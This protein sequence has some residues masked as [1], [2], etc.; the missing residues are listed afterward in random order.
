[1][2]AQAQTS[3]RRSRKTLAEAVITNAEASAADHQV[4]VALAAYFIAERR[5][6]E[7]GHELDDWLAAEAQLAQAEQP[8][9][10]SSIQLIKPENV[11]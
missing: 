4:K 3:G 2:N 1:V 9:V 10:R 6:F 7:P 11:S 8:R 5:G